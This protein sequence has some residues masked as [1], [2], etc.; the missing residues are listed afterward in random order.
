MTLVF[1]IYLAQELESLKQLS[2]F[3]MILKNVWIRGSNYYKLLSFNNS[4]CIL[5]ICTDLSYEYMINCKE[6]DQFKSASLPD[7]VL[8]FL[9]K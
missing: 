6:N 8:C 1:P 7:I 3:L 5:Y 9:R 4:F 2:R